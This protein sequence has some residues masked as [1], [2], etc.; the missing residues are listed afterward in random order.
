MKMVSIDRFLIGEPMRFISTFRQFFIPSESSKNPRQLAQ[1]LKNMTQSDSSS[2]IFV[3]WI[4][5]LK[6]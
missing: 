3:T 2:P 6:L 1:D 4:S 5:L